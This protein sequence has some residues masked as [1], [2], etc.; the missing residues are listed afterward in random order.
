MWEKVS[1]LSQPLPMGVAIAVDFNP[2]ADRLRIV[3][4]NGMSLR[5]N[6]QDGQATVD[7]SLKYADMDTHKGM[8][9]RVA[10][11]GYT[12]SMAGSKETAL[13]D[14]DLG[15]AVLVRQAPPNDG[16]LSTVGALGVP[17]DG[18]V[19]FDVWSDGMGKNVGWMISGG[20]LY[21]VDLISGKATMAAPITGL[22]GRT[23]DLA[24]L[25]SM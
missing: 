20:H 15:H 10:A 23:I 24:I 8:T 3:T 6:V 9:P 18:A 1:Q 5:V 4:A 25:P 21:S 17:L 22:T 7:G 11:A 13:Y 12:N 2:V 14:I 19:A 16:I